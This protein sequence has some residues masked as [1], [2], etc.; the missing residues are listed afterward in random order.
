MC[1]QFLQRRRCSLAAV[2]MPPPRPKRRL[3]P[4]RLR[5]LKLRRR[6]RRRPK[7][8]HP[9]R[10]SNSAEY[11]S[12]GTPVANAAGVL[13]YA[14]DDIVC[15]LPR[16]RV[17]QRGRAAWRQLFLHRFEGEMEVPRMKLKAIN[18]LVLTFAGFALLGCNQNPTPAPAPTPGPQVTPPPAEPPPAEPAPAGQPP[19]AP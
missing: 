16:S 2:R 6:N 8:L 11:A 15:R 18:A 9:K 17:F 13:S 7:L 14:A 3:Q 10:R 19:P 1:L 4:K 5:R 12:F